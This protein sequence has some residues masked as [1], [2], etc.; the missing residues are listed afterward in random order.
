MPPL[1]HSKCASFDMRLDRKSCR[2]KKIK[3]HDEI[4]FYSH[5]CERTL[6]LSDQLRSQCRKQR[7]KNPGSDDDDETLDGTYNPD[8]GAPSLHDLV[9]LPAPRTA[10]THKRCI[11]SESTNN[12]SA[13]TLS[14]RGSALNGTSVYA[15]EGCRVCPSHAVTFETAIEDLRSIPTMSRRTLMEVTELRSFSC[16]FTGACFRNG[17]HRMDVEDPR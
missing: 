1:K 16:E 6:H 15:S 2:Y 11:T 13:I 7:E 5:G 14:I 4:I 9:H 17:V 12:L 10:S 8:P 3:T